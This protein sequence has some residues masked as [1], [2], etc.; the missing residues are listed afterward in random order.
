[1]SMAIADSEAF[2]KTNFLVLLDI[3]G[4]SNPLASVVNTRKS[5]PS[6]ARFRQS[7]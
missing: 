4:G 5:Q 3:E 7:S 1:M 2:L 6:N